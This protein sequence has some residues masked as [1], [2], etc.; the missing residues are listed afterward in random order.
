MSGSPS[1]LPSISRV[2]SLYMSIDNT[3]D[4]ASI[5]G[6][7]TTGCMLEWT[8][9]PA[10][11]PYHRNKGRAS[12]RC[13]G[14][15]VGGDWTMIQIQTDT[16]AN[17]ATPACSDGNA[18]Y[19]PLG[20]WGVHELSCTEDATASQGQTDVHPRLQKDMPGIKSSTLEAKAVLP[21][22]LAPARPTCTKPQ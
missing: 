15:A 3:T 9:W 13:H 4:P 17:N 18:A 12:V 10:Q 2:A 11:S 19:V 6:C 1:K 16:C 14:S 22:P 5:Y 21:A 20:W 7:F 8:A